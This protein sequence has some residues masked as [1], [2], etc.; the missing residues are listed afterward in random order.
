V[1]ARAAGQTPSFSQAVARWRDEEPFQAW[2]GSESF[3][4]GY[5]SAA[6]GQGG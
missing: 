5:C 1:L 4:H 2:L 3:A 6:E